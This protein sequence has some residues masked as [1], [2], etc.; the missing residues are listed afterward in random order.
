MQNQGN[1]GQWKS[2]FWYILCSETAY[3]E[4]RLISEGERPFPDIL[5]VTD[6]LDLRELV[7]T[8][9]IQKDFDSVNHLFLITTLKKL[10]SV[11][12]LLSEYKFY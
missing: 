4:G 2:V 8:V 1:T 3:V 6:F 11:K 9:D 10:V 7:V 5:Q 12:H